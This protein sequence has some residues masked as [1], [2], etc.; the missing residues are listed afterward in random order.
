[1]FSQI[2]SNN[3]LFIVEELL[4]NQD[5]FV[6]G[7]VLSE[8]LGVTRVAIKKS[9]S[10]LNSLGYDI[11]ARTG[12][13]YRLKKLPDYPEEKAVI[14]LLKARGIEN[15]YYKFFERIDSTQDEAA[16][17]LSKHR[18]RLDRDRNF[19]F[20]AL[21]QTKGRG[22]YFRS[23][24]SSKGGI[25]FTT[26]YSEFVEVEKLPYYNLSVAIS[27]ADYLREKYGIEAEL[28]WPNDVMIGEKKVAGILTT[29]RIE[30][31]VASHIVIGVGINVNN[32]IPQELS[33]IA[34]S[35]KSITKE[36]INLLTFFIDVFSLML[37][38][39]KMVEK[40][41][42]KPIVSRANDILWK[43][44]QVTVVSDF[45]GNRFE[46]KIVKIGDRGE[47][48]AETDEGEI[49]VFAAELFNF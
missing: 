11:E 14:S 30:V 25:W 47:L 6:S 16:R 37:D 23:W 41:G 20:L 32:D 28:K 29:A 31:D 33:G 49:T 5:R 36:E 18:F 35:V 15:V 27:V 21:E 38:N 10:K 2:G 8:K 42:G 45:R 7:E 9:M 24:H 19:V 34:V 44:G 1:M 40:E 46:A 48:V 3:L 22:R 39:L 17:F 13:G 4:K 12:L 43:K 26:I